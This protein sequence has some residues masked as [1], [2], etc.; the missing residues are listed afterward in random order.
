MTANNS[1]LVSPC[2]LSEQFNSELLATL[3]MLSEEGL[4]FKVK[5]ANDKNAHLLVIDVD[6]ESG[7]QQLS[8]S[9]PGQVK[10]L[11]SSTLESGKNVVGLIKPVNKDKLKNVLSKLFKTMQI[12]LSI[13]SEEKNLK[14]TADNL[15][16]SDNNIDKEANHNITETVF[17]DFLMAKKNKTTFHITS[18]ETEIFVDGE[19]QSLKTLGT[20]DDVRRLIS[21]PYNQL[22]VKTIDSGQF[23]DKT[24]NLQ[25]ITLHNVLWTAAIICSNGLL[26]PGHDENQAVKLR[27]WPSFTRN[28]FKAEHLKLAALLAQRPISLSEL[29]KQTDITYIEIVNFYNA[30]VAVDLID[31]NPQEYKQPVKKAVTNT[32]QKKSNLFNKIAARLGLSQHLNGTYSG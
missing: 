15:N 5:S 23:L 30:A 28:D 10:L 18:N 27:A 20:I 14:N 22:N 2:N 8:E 3:S 25:V 24:Q 4:L 7:R 12:Q 11:I 19:N 32:N 6:T 29:S 13:K 1:I 16:K 9:M 17:Y 21:L 31:K 26:L